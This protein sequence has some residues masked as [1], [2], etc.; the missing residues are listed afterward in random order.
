M[1]CGFEDVLDG[2][3]TL[4]FFYCQKILI[5]YPKIMIYDDHKKPPEVDTDTWL[6]MLIKWAN[7]VP[8]KD[9]GS[10]DVRTVMSSISHKCPFGGNPQDCFIHQVRAKPYEERVK[11]LNELS[12]FQLQALHQ[13]HLDCRRCQSGGAMEE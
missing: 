4:N 8:F 6:G 7:G 13:V 2:N 3:T 11:W 12:E 9:I 1:G 5:F 10:D